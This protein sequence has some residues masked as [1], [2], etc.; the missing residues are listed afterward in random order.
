MSE[1]EI[2]VLFFLLPPLQLFILDFLLAG[3]T[4]TAF[5]ARAAV[6]SKV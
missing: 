2:N 1:S 6:S 4:N 5:S 3:L